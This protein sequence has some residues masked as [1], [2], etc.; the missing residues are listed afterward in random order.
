MSNNSFLRNRISLTMLPLAGLLAVLGL[1]LRGPFGNPSTNPSAFAQ[2]AASPNFGT[3]W[4]IILLGS[5]VRI[6][7]LMVLFAILAQTRA[8]RWVFWA[9]LFSFVSEALFLSLTGILAFAAPV[10]AKLYLQGDTGLI[11][12][13]KAGFF[14]GPGLALLYPSG[15]IGTLGSILFSIAIYRSNLPVWAGII[16]AL[17]TPLLAFAPAFSYILELLGGVLLLVSGTWIAVAVWRHQS[18]SETT[19]RT[20]QP[21]LMGQA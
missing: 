14:S 8:A 15:L 3:A 20:G 11:N 1:L 7:S 9:L 19:S 10:A 6:Y 5:V 16:Y 17:T 18:A 2:A 4:V 12:V 21:S 13:L